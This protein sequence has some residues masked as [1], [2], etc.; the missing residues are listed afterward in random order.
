MLDAFHMNQGLDPST[1]DE[2]LT[3]PCNSVF[4]ESDAV[5]WPAQVYIHIQ[6]HR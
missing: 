4:K 6:M 3:A 5:F 1:N 2:Q